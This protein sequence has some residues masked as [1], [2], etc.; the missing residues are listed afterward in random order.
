MTAKYAMTLDGR[1]ATVTGDSQWITNEASRRRVHRIRDLND[2]VLV[3][4]RTLV[5][6]DPR[7]TTRDVVG[8]RDA[9]RVV[10]DARGEISERARVLSDDSAA[11]CWIACGTDWAERLSHRLAGRAEVIALGLDA[12]GR[13]PVVPLLEELARRDI[14][15]VMVEGG[16]ETLGSFFAC[17]EIDHVVAFLAPRIIGGSRAPGPIGGPGVSEIAAGVSLARTEVERFGDELLVSGRVAKREA[18]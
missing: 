8:G 10:L 7:L 4:H 14:M 2:A 1:I 16:A 9:V 15:T 18:T 5:R 17:G 13:L 11:P 3:G 12:E 6:D